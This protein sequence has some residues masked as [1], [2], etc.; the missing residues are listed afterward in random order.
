MKET[1]TSFTIAEM[2]NMS[3]AEI[4]DI[5]NEYR[6]SRKLAEARINLLNALNKY[7]E[8]LGLDISEQAFEAFI[9]SLSSYEKMVNSV[10]NLDITDPLASLAQLIESL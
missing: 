6:D 1:K 7:A 8:S 10:K 5:V 3:D 2:A 4:L 9:E